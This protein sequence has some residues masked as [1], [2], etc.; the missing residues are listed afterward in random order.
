MVLQTLRNTFGTLAEHRVGDAD[1]LLMT[2]TVAELSRAAGF[3]PA[4]PANATARDVE[5]LHEA[6]ALQHGILVYTATRV[7][8][9][10]APWDF[11]L[12]DPVDI[13]DA[14]V[15]SRPTETLTKMAIARQ[16]QLRDALSDEARN[17]QWAAMTKTAL[18]AVLVPPPAGVGAAPV[19]VALAA[20]PGADA[21]GRGGGRGLGG[22]PARGGRGRRGGGK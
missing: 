8:A 9:S 5:L 11:V 15:L 13:E 20:P 6:R 19:P 4:F 22:R 10:D 14:F 17:R 7:G 3:H 18:L 1:A 16:L 21:P 2:M 12:T